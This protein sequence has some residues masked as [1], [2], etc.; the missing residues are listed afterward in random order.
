[1]ALGEDVLLTTAGAKNLM[2]VVDNRGENMQVVVIRF[3]DVMPDEESA[4][5]LMESEFG[6]TRSSTLFTDRLALQRAM[7]TPT[8]IGEMLTKGL[9][10]NEVLSYGC[11]DGFLG[12]CT[13][14]N[15]QDL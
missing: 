13:T 3:D 5:K 10:L 4:V 9:V 14:V 11:A 7:N 2:P 8:P 15:S 1:M 6:I 12:I